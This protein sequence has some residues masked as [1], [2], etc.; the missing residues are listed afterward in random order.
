[1]LKTNKKFEIRSL[2]SPQRNLGQPRFLALQTQEQVQGRKVI[3]NFVEN[4]TLFVTISESI[5]PNI[6]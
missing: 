3:E 4:S 1:M 5:S 6:V 2:K